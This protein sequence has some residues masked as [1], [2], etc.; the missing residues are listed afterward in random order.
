MNGLRHS[1]FHG[2]FSQ[3]LEVLGHSVNVEITLI[4]ADVV[5]ITVVWVNFWV[6]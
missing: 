2:V 5:Y 3:E 1:E 4:K 6:C